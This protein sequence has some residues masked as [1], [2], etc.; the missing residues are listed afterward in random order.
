MIWVTL[1]VLAVAGGALLMPGYMEAKSDLYA[2]MVA[3][4]ATSGLLFLLL[5]LSLIAVIIRWREDFDMPTSGIALCIALAFGTYAMTQVTYAGIR[6]QLI[7][8]YLLIVV[9]LRQYMP[10]RKRVAPQLAM[11]LLVIGLIGFTGRLHNMSDEQGHGSSP[12]LP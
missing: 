5:Q 3:P 7:L 11:W 9:L 12:F 2:D 8:F 1:S 4:N 6:F 10:V